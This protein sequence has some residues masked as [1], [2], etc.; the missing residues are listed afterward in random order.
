MY[1]K[2]ALAAILIATSV[3]AHEKSTESLESLFE[4][5]TSRKGTDVSCYNF[6]DL[7]ALLEEYPDVAEEYKA[8]SKDDQEKLLDSIDIF[9]YAFNEAFTEVIASLD[10][11]SQST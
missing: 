2:G 6:I 9:N 10:D 7:E 3:C 8:L 11:E 1:V 5:T 4:G